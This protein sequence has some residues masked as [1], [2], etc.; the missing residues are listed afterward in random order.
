MLESVEFEPNSQLLSI[1]N[2]AFKDNPLDN[3]PLP[4]INN[5]YW[6]K[7][8]E[9]T[10]IDEVDDKTAL[11]TAVSSNAPDY[12]FDSKTKTIIDYVGTSKTIT[13][14]SSIDGVTVEAIG[15]SAFYENHLTSVTIPASVTT[16]AKEAFC[17]NELVNVMFE[18]GS[19]LQTIGSDAF[20]GNEL[21][22]ITIPVSVTSIGEWAFS[23]NLLESITIPSSVKNISQKAFAY[24][25]LSSVTF[26][27]GSQL[28]TIEVSVFTSTPL[29][30]SRSPLL[31]H[32]SKKRHLQ[33]IALVQLA[34]NQDLNSKPLKKEHLHQTYL[35][36]LLYL[37]QLLRLV[38]Q[39]LQTI[40]LVRLALK[41]RTLS[42]TV[43]VK[44][45]FQT[46]TLSLQSFYLR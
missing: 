1:Y 16:I 27:P 8:S 26:S 29:V 31:L 24:N 3:I 30:Q 11:Y 10:P 45:H 13:I 28:T 35:H 39:H 4:P 38:K 5:K 42:F 17:W 14:P 23:E 7:N 40:A 18:T 32:A 34:S 21:I 22:S 20:R 43:L 25:N 44:A 37:P 19:Q 41:Q 46:I 9:T 12:A 36:R 33:T 2:D 15:E 6:R